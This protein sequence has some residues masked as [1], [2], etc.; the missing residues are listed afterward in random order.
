MLENGFYVKKVNGNIHFKDVARYNK[1][2]A[3]HTEIKS[4]IDSQ[5]NLIGHLKQWK[6]NWGPELGRPTNFLIEKHILDETF[7]DVDNTDWI[8]I[9]EVLITQ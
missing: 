7:E 5:G 3:S 4:E 1:D 6:G 2:M 9:K 8:L